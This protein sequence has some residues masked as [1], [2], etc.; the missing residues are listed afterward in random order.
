[1]TDCKW[2]IMEVQK[3]IKHITTDC[4]E[5]FYCNQCRTNVGD[6]GRVMLKLFTDATLPRRDHFFGEP[7][8]LFN[9]VRKKQIRQVFGENKNGI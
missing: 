4:V 3:L 5:G 6:S 8:G 9:L 1:M 7:A 2:N